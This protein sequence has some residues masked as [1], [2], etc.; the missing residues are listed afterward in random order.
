MYLWWDSIHHNEWDIDG[1]HVV[2][3]AEKSNISPLVE[4]FSGRGG[5]F[6]ALVCDIESDLFTD[7]SSTTLSDSNCPAN[8]FS[9]GFPM[10]LK[11]RDMHSLAAVDA[12]AKSS[13]SSCFCFARFL[14][15]HQQWNAENESA[16]IIASL[17]SYWYNSSRKQK[18]K[19][20]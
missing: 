11:T 10:A 4:L 3:I 5:F 19:N 6:C 17:W 14:V 13:C 15:P 8:S 12:A 18:A 9:F 16:D 2:D 1:N 20:W 7:S